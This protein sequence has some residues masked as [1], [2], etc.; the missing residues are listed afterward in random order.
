MLNAMTWERNRGRRAL[1]GEVGYVDMYHC[2]N[3]FDLSVLNF[4]QT[5]GSF[6]GS[7]KIIELFNVRSEAKY[8][9]TFLL[10][11]RQRPWPNSLKGYPILP[12]S[13]NEARNVDKYRI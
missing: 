4:I 11:F 1:R 10:A 8:S 2:S 3:I 7:N 9:G 13:L 6:L 12:L 5:Y